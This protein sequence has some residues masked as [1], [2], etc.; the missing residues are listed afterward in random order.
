MVSKCL[1]GIKSRNYIFKVLVYPKLLSTCFSAACCS[2]LPEGRGHRQTDTH[3]GAWAT[4]TTLY[5]KGWDSY[6][7]AT[8]LTLAPVRPFRL[9][10]PPPTH[11]SSLA[12][13][14]INVMTRCEK[15]TLSL[16]HGGAETFLPTPKVTPSRRL[17]DLTKGAFSSPSKINET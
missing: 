16:C 6:I 8:W 11:S 9:S 2:E 15:K 12:S 17:G 14:V 4:S 10:P 3:T 1:Y 7:A 13:L 5:D